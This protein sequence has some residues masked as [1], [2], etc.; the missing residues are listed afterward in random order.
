MAWNNRQPDT[1]DTPSFSFVRRA[2]D[3]VEVNQ[4]LHSL[5]GEDRSSR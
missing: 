4:Y 2:Y 5:D 3:P 1:A